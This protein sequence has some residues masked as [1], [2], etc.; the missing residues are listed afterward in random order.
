[1]EAGD[2]PDSGGAEPLEDSEP[3]DRDRP[4]VGDVSRD[5]ESRDS[6][7]ETVSSGTDVLPDE[8]GSSSGSSASAMRDTGSRDDLR[9]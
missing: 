1:Q 7:E 4:E 6:V 2:D 9:T 8:Q 3:G 5:V